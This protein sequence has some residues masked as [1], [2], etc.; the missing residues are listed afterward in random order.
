MLLP[1]LAAGQQTERDVAYRTGGGPYA[2]NRCRMDIYTPA[3]AAGKPLPVVVWFHG[4]GL[5]G[6][7]K[8]IPTELK[9]K[10]LVV[11][12]VNYRLLS[13][14]AAGGLPAFGGSSL[15]ETIDDAACAVSWIMRNIASRGGDT[16][17]VVLAGHSAGG[18]LVSM[19]GL[20][21]SWLAAYGIDADRMAAL[22]PLSGQAITHFAQRERLGVGPLQPL[23]D[24]YAPLFHVRKDCPPY[25]VVTA[26]RNM[27]LF[28]RYEEN[29][30]MWRMM[31]LVGHP[32]CRIYEIGGFDHGAMAVP[33]FHILLEELKGM[34][35]YGE[36]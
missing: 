19:V 26:D 3:K 17:R 10:G 33:G 21:K 25:I 23:V 11:A 4:G 12:A 35:I 8:S 24:R 9:E 36:Q 18:Y 28:G 34:R 7:G 14:E 13:G 22:V 20:D 27:E 5:T 2:D 15:D 31:Q 16:T 6:G 1:L 29:A 32:A 30:Y